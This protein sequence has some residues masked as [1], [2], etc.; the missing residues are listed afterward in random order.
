MSAETYDGG[1]NY[2]SMAAWAKEHITKPI[3]SIHKISNCNAPEKKMIEALSAKP[4][5][6]LEAIIGKV[7]ARVK[8]H[9]K[10]FDA[11]VSVIQAQY[12]SMVQEFNKNL[13]LVKDEFNYKYVDQLLN[14]RR[15]AAAEAAAAGGSSSGDEL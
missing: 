11:K 1:R 4:D 6:E 12:D 14:I 7:E 8:Q 5:D 3:C 13:E 10:D 15:D 9:E 2:D